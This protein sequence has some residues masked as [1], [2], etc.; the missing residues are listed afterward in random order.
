MPACDEASR[1]L[2]EF[3]FARHYPQELLWACRQDLYSI[4]PTNHFIKWPLPEANN[5]YAR[6]SYENG[7][8]R[9][10]V[11]V[12]ALF[13]VDNYSIATVFA[14]M[15]DEIQGWDQGLKVAIHNPY[16]AAHPI[17]SRLVWQLHKFRAAFRR[18]QRYEAFI[19]ERK[20]Q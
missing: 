11:E 15:K 14:P 5:E 8:K 13:T 16:V 20:Q 10:I 17:K 19:Q 3:L 12:K 1:S 9:G 2:S 7:R 18:Y 6:L 4:G